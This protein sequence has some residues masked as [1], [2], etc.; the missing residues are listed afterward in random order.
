MSSVYDTIDFLLSPNVIRATVAAVAL[1]LTLCS[2]LA[3]K[4]QGQTRWDVKQA[5]WKYAFPALIPVTLGWVWLSVVNKTAPEPYLVSDF[6]VL[7]SASSNDWAA[8][9]EFF[10]IPQAQVYCEGKYFQWD[11]KI[12]TPPGL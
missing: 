12:T 11:D 8:Q 7:A 3:T 4:P 1:G 5:V 6:P 9:D 10:H 2:G